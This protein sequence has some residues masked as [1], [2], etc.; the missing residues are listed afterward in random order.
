ML[1][2]TNSTGRFANVSNSLMDDISE[3]SYKSVIDGEV[4]YVVNL[5]GGG[6]DLVYIQS[7]IISHN[8]ESIE[9]VSLNVHVHVQC[10]QY[11]Y[12]TCMGLYSTCTVY[13]GLYM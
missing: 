1:P 5:L 7:V 11:M 12:C 9:S 13:M 8:D 10:I 2:N 3:F 6:G 4:V